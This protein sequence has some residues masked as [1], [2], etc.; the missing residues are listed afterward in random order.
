[1]KVACLFM[2]HAITPYRE[3]KNLGLAYNN[4]MQQ[5]PD[6]DWACITDWD[7]LY[8]L[9]ETISHLNEYTRLLPDTGIFTCYGSRSHVNSVNQML[10]AGRSE[11]D[12][13]R[14]HIDVA[15]KQTEQLYKA[16][17]L[18]RHLSGFL[19]MISKATWDQYKFIDNMKCL[20]VDNIYSNKILAAGLPIRRMDG[21]Y[22][23]HSY[24]IDKDVKDTSHL[25]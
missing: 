12:N 23:W 7:V 21:V 3:D 17:D 13:I 15:K 1:M 22:V 4:A 18:F 20:D 11:I 14:Y 5:I 9:P 10:P 25:L 6:G 16:T 19:M 2:V 24:R 8:L